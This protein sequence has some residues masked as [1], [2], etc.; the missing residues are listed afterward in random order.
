MYDLSEEEKEHKTIAIRT[1][2][3][4]TFPQSFLKE[5]RARAADK[6]KRRQKTKAEYNKERKRDFRFEK[7]HNDAKSE[8]IADSLARDGI[9]SYAALGAAVDDPYSRDFDN[10]LL[11]ETIRQVHPKLH[12]FDK[13]RMIDLAGQRIGTSGLETLL[14]QMDRCPIEVLGLTDNLLDDSSLELLATRIRSFSKLKELYLNQNKITDDGIQSLF[15]TNTYPSNLEVINLARNVMNTRCAYFLGMMFAKERKEAKLHTLILGGQIGRRGWGDEFIRVLAGF[16]ALP[17]SRS[18]RKLSFADA[19]M[20][21]TGMT[22]ISLI[23][24]CCPTLHEVNIERNHVRSPRLHDALTAALTIHTKIKLIHEHQCGLDRLDRHKVQESL[25]RKVKLDWRQQTVLALCLAQETHRSRALRIASKLSIF[26][27]PSQAAAPWPRKV[28]GHA[29]SLDIPDS[30]SSRAKHEFY[31]VLLDSR[32][33]L[34]QRQLTTFLSSMPLLVMDDTKKLIAAITNT[35][36]LAHTLYEMLDESVKL[37]DVRGLKAVVKS[38]LENKKYFSG[39]IDE[40]VQ[41]LDKFSTMAKARKRRGNGKGRAK[42]FANFQEGVLMSLADCNDRLRLY[43]SD[44]ERMI[45]LVHKYKRDLTGVSTQLDLVDE[46]KDLLPYATLGPA[47]YFTHFVCIAKPFDL[48]NA[49]KIEEQARMK[50]ALARK[51]AE[52]NARK[53]VK[54]K[55]KVFGKR[56]MIEDGA[57]LR[58]G[59][60]WAAQAGKALDESPQSPSVESVE[61]SPDKRGLPVSVF[62]WA[63]QTEQVE[64][65]DATQTSYTN[66]TSSLDDSLDYI[67]EGPDLSPLYRMNRTMMQKYF[68]EDSMMVQRMHAFGREEM[69]YLSH[70]RAVGQTS[71]EVEEV[72]GDVP[73]PITRSHLA[74]SLIRIEDKLRAILDGRKDGRARELQS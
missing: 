71:I 73:I 31:H 40:T 39:N 70:R 63:G 57:G 42:G 23:I 3:A 52:K 62:Q 15:H 22:A 20:S 35:A 45:G 5:G 27:K 72:R 47:A 12:T 60:Y 6:L 37:S 1:L 44:V 74:R 16:F 50:E 41:V 61:H 2:L 25:R 34:C 36:T 18:L 19:G 17:G 53:S 58:D 67:D 28:H 8:E 68:E 13:V 56:F 11:R 14:N 30:Q 43:S 69:R 32:I 38:F 59:S 7:S 48:F 24:T 26:N 54:N 46:A 21:S 64:N 65:V 4:T 29:P 55:R 49:K 33:I 10:S 51:I 66:F 9:V